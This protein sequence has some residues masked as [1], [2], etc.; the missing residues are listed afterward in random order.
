MADQGFGARHMVLAARDGRLGKEGRVGPAPVGRIPDVLIESETLLELRTFPLAD[1]LRTAAK[2]GKKKAFEDQVAVVVNMLRVF[3]CDIMFLSCQRAEPASLLARHRDTLRMFDLLLLMCK[4]PTMLVAWLYTEDRQRWVVQRIGQVVGA[5]DGVSTILISSPSELYSRGKHGLPE[6]IED[7][8]F[9]CPLLSA[10]VSDKFRLLPLARMLAGAARGWWTDLDQVFVADEHGSGRTRIGEWWMMTAADLPGMGS[11][12]LV[13]QGSEV[14]SVH[15]SKGWPKRDR[16]SNSHFLPAAC[17]IPKLHPENAVS[18]LL[19]VPNTDIAY[20][21]MGKSAW[22]RRLGHLSTELEV[23]LDGNF[24]V[25]RSEQW[26]IPT[27]HRNH[28]SWNAEAETALWPTIAKWLWKGILEYVD[29]HCRLPMCILACGAVPKSTAPMF[30][31]ITDF[32]PTNKFVDAWPVKYISLKGL[33]LILTRNSIFWWRDLD[34][35]YLQSVLGGCGRPW[36][37][38]QRWIL[39]Q[40]KSG[41]RP[42]I[43]RCYGCDSSSCGGTCDK[44]MSGI[45][46]SGH[47]MRFA[48]PQFGGKTSHGPLAV[49]T[50]EFIR[51]IIRMIEIY[52][53]AYVDDMIFALLAAWHGVCAG[54]HG[55]CA[56]CLE[57]LGKARAHETWIDMVMADLHLNCST[58]RGVPGQR[59]AF[60]GVI[61]DTFLGRMLLTDEKLTKLMSGLQSLMT[62]GDASPRDLSK[63]RGKLINYSLC[64]QRIK[65]FIIPFTKF[66]GS[67]QNDAEWDSRS[68]HLEYVKENALYLIQWLPSL[69]ALGAPL[70]DLETSTLYE[71]WLD[72]RATGLKIILATWDAAIPGT[73]M[74]FRDEPAHIRHCVGRRFDELST[75]AT[76]PADW[77]QGGSLDHQVHREGWGGVLT[78]RTLLEDDAVRDCILL[79]RNDCAPALAALEKGSSRSPTLQAAAVQLHMMCIPRGIFP[80]FLHTSG[81]ELV[82][83]GVDDGSRAKARALQGPACG[84]ALRVNI[85]KFARD[86]GWELTMDFFASACNHLTE[87]YMS[88]TEDPDCEQTDAFAARSWNVSYCPFCKCIHQ[89]TGFFFTPAGLEDKVVRRARSD[90]ARGLFLVPCNPKAP[91]FVALKTASRASMVVEPV[92][93][94]FTHVKKPMCKHMLFAV[95]FG[96]ADPHVRACGQATTR[97]PKERWVRPVEAA[98]SEA[99]LDKLR[100]MA[101]QPR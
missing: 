59:D 49:V 12:T 5:G 97:R 40:D 98:E 46:L 100:D 79:L 60:M 68:V 29:R 10:F 65:P 36:R 85:V 76:F 66:I 9:L 56:L 16:P 43:S 57:N 82:R 99:I 63:L 47:V 92:G 74:V 88:W 45:C 70:W 38:V 14:V 32:R 90:G 19:D 75:V 69:A 27:F 31:L 94:T 13:C 2:E 1:R 51:Y 87:R 23:L 50:D 18:T 67:P 62:W 3:M 22:V 91:F 72:G 78:V 6:R 15:F 52:G 37:Q 11:A 7:A 28:P 55:G 54:L 101:T 83:E 20:L 30:R 64:I 33:S 26:W 42:M 86:Q 81:E 58:K 84:G 61:I 41:Y 73:A 89:E 8:P 96:G 24:C 4:E 21:A 95:D 48:G 17:R 93:A 25:S 44:S 71:H 80:R 53:A 39:S 35:A 34:C 77:S